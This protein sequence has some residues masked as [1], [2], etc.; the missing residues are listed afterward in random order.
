MLFIK[1]L[2]PWILTAPEKVAS[3]LLSRVNTVDI[4]ALPSVVL[5]TILPPFSL[6]D[7]PASQKDSIWA[8]TVRLLLA[9]SAPSNVIIPSLWL[10]A[11][12]APS[13]DE[14]L[15]APPSVALLAVGS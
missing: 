4:L 8:P 14:S 10:S 11:I 1:D 5:N 15:N 12:A 3:L 7:Q 2:L 9:S 13:S 6:A